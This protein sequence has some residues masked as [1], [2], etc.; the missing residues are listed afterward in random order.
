M[1]EHRSHMYVNEYGETVALPNATVWEDTKTTR[2]TYHGDDGKQFR[3]IVRQKP[4]PIGFTARLPGDYRQG[5]K[6]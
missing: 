1:A 6:R 3:T 4:N 2:V 5:S